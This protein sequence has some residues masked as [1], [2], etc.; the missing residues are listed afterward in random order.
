MSEKDITDRVEELHEKTALSEQEARVQ[1]LRERG[2]ERQEIAEELDIA[3]STVREYVKRVDNKRREAKSTASVLEGDSEDEGSDEG[4]YP[5]LF[6]AP[7]SNEHA[8]EHFENTVLTGV[9]VADYEDEIP[10]QLQDSER[11]PIWGTGE[12]NA[13]AA[14]AIE[15]GDII[16]FYVG[17]KTYSHIATVRSTEVNEDLARSIWR[18][19]EGDTWPYV[20][21]L[22]D[23]VEVDLD[24]VA[25]HDDIGYDIAYPLGFTRVDEQRVDELR[26]QHG[27][28]EDYFESARARHAF[29]EGEQLSIDMYVGGEGETIDSVNADED[30][31]PSLAELREIAEKDGSETTTTTTTTTTRYDR[32]AAVKAYA[33]ARADGVCEG[34]GKDAPFTSR[35]G[36][37]Y[38][39][40]HHVFEVSDE[41]PD[42]PDAVIAL[43]PTCHRRVHNGEDGNEYNRELI[44]TLD[45]IESDLDLE[46]A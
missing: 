24:S 45:D 33:R 4:R 17:D 21:Y 18:D 37:P 43:C 8:Q 14:D 40:V 23:P 29:E 20:I 7:C 42:K 10:E 27:S 39:E 44:E 34:C 25:F 15:P 16:A 31:E 30:D 9:S 1:A 5:R 38:L 32:S 28:L 11:I 2:L 26:L 13:T 22:D 6:L 3:K 46:T 19:K 36:D 35:T 41:G 12:G